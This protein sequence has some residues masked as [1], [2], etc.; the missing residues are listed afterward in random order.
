MR[1]QQRTPLGTLAGTLVIVMSALTGTAC[2]DETCERL[3]ALSVEQKG[4]VLASDDRNNPECT[5]ALLRSL[6]KAE[7]VE[8][9]RTIANYLDFHWPEREPRY[10]GG[11]HL[12]WEGE[13]YPALD[14]LYAIGERSEPA[15]LDYLADDGCQALGCRHAALLFLLFQR[16]GD[17]PKAV[18]ILARAARARRDAVQ[19]SRLWRAATEA[20]AMCT[21]DMQGSCRAALITPSAK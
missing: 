20:A 12:P 19:A 16:S 9:S 6:G 2:A 7:Y 17:F 15:L 13:V 5:A 10:D 4:Q 18:A 14:A 21:P 1:P 3:A 11:S 8:A